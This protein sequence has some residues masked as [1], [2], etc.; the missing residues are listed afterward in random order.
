[1]RLQLDPLERRAVVAQ[2]YPVLGAAVDEERIVMQR[3]EQ[4][5]QHVVGNVGRQP[6]IVRLQ[7]AV[8]DLV[9]GARGRGHATGGRH[10]V[11][12]SGF[13]IEGATG[14]CH[15]MRAPFGYVRSSMRVGFLPLATK[16]ACIIGGPIVCNF[17]GEC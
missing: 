15:A 12:P 4:W 11:A 8:N 9:P 3:G 17:G 1:V 13:M 14:A 7:G 5:L 16:T 10:G 2:R 6:D